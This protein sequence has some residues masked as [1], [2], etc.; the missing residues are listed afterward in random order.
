MEVAPP[1]LASA[2]EMSVPSLVNTCVLLPGLKSADAPEA[3][4]YSIFPR[5]IASTRF[6]S[7]AVE[8]TPSRI[9]SSAVVEVTPS[10]ILSSA[11]VEVTPSR[12][13]SSAVVE[14]TPSRML[15]SAAVEVTPSRILSSA[16]VDVTVVP[17]IDKASV[18]RVPSMSA[19]PLTSKEP[20][21]SSPDRVKFRRPV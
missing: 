8:V 20:A 19:F 13:L 21:S 1:P 18:S 11:V 2:H 10:R 17:L 3:L 5:A 14:V 16:A 6:N 12:I 15:S 7:A 9:L 4:P